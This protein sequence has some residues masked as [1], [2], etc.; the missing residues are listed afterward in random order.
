LIF[1][2]TP[3]GVGSAQKPVPVWM[4]KGDNLEVEIEG[5]GILRNP[6]IDAVPT[7][8]SATMSLVES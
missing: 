6:V 5:I 4:K 3:G 8:A 2:G 1:T 7:N